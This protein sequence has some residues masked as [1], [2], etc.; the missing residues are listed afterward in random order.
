MHRLMDSVKESRDGE[1]NKID[2]KRAR[3]MSLRACVATAAA[4]TL[5]GTNALPIQKVSINKIARLK[6]GGS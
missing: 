6:V 3:G 1:T 4:W 2:N 5:E